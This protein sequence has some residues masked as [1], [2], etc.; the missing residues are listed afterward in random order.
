M[1]GVSE[2]IDKHYPANKKVTMARGCFDDTKGAVIV[3]SLSARD[4]SALGLDTYCKQYYLCLAAATATIKWLGLVSNCSNGYWSIKVIKW[5]KE[6][7]HLWC[8]AGASG[9]DSILSAPAH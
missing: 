2:L 5:V 1:V 3:R 6:E 8:R 7:S 4:P 9:L